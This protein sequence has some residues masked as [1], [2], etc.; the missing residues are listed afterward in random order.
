MIPGSCLCG[1]VHYTVSG[2]LRPVTGCHCRQ[3]RKTSGHPV[4]ATG[5][6]RADVAFTGGVQWYRSSPSVRRG[7]CPVC[8][9]NLFWC[10][11]GSHL[12][13]FAGTLDTDAGISLAGHILCADKGAY[14]DI[15]D[16]DLPHIAGN[17]PL[18]TMTLP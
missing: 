5:A 16:H 8:G 7:F 14:Y 11:P 6:A 12:S 10:G 3:C 4:A 1:A 15:L 13:V 9:S 17:D 18:L 2:P